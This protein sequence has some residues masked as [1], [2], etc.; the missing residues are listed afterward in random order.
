[1]QEHEFTTEQYSE[2]SENSEDQKLNSAT[3][4]TETLPNVSADK[5]LPEQETVVFSRPAQDFADTQNVSPISQTV[6]A[7]DEELFG[8]YEIR[9]WDFTPRIYKILSISAIFNILFLVAVAQTD[10]LRTKACDSPLVGGFCQ[11]IDT[12]YVGGKILSTDSAFVDK[13]Y[14]RSELENAEIVWV[15]KTGLEPPMTYP[16][17]YFQIANPQMF[18]PEGDPFLNGSD[19]NFPSV[20]NTAPPITNPTSP[21]PIMPSPPVSKGSGVFNRPPRPIRNNPNAI[22]GKLPDGIKIPTTDDPTTANT[23]DKEKETTADNKTKEEPV[24]NNPKSDPITDIELNRQPLI[25]HGKYVSGL[26]NENKVDL[27]T[28]F[29]V[30]AKGKLNKDGKLEK[31]SFKIVNAQSSDQDMIDVI[32]RSIAAINDSGYLKYLEQLSGKDLNLLIK[33]DDQNVSAVVESELESETRAKS[34]KSTLELAISLVKSRKTGEN[35]DDNDRDDLALLEGAKVERQGKKIIIKFDVKKDIAQSMIERKLKI[36]KDS[37]T[38]KPNSTA[39][40]VI[41]KENTGK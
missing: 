38:A 20:I 25:D 9:N 13:P 11:V 32:V 1:M 15:D 40:T 3:P 23:K 36:S 41:P 21:N 19:P 31:D 12:L 27:K 37:P 24:K 39:Q 18:P 8:K 16:A 6:A 28:P 4:E 10:V 2:N 35:Q 22:V 5:E 17:G 30:Q 33:Q 7:G 29:L 34:L 26:L 14:E